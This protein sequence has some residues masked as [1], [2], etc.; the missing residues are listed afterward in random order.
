MAGMV[1]TVAFLLVRF[2][3]RD[4]DAKFVTGFDEVFTDDGIRILETRVQAPRANAFAERWVRTVR[5][6]CLDSTLIWNRRHAEHVLTTYV[7]HYNR[8]RPHRGIDL[9]TPDPPTSA[10]DPS[11]PIRHIDRLGGLLHEYQRAA[12]SRP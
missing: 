1:S 7:E 6:E 5:S 11:G 9:D 8:A 12:W 4:R 10:G 2:L 3:I